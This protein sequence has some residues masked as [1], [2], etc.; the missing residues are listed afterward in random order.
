MDSIAY[1]FKKNKADGEDAWRR[2]PPN[3]ALERPPLIIRR[4][5]RG[6]S[7]GMGSVE[8]KAKLCHIVSDNYNALAH[9]DRQPSRFTGPDYGAIGRSLIHIA[10]IS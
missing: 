6:N 4:S 7:P 5:G 10:P 2:W 8:K 3:M 9:M 1:V